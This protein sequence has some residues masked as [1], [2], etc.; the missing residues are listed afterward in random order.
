MESAYHDWD[1]ISTYIVAI[2]MIVIIN[3]VILLTINDFGNGGF[4]QRTRC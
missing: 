4:K 2:I 3:K 1:I